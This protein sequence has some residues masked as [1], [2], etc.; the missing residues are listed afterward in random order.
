M[1]LVDEAFAT[2]Y[3]LVDDTW[4]YPLRQGT[5]LRAE[6][7]G[8]AYASPADLPLV[9]EAGTKAAATTALHRRRIAL[10]DKQAEAVM[11]A[12]APFLARVDVKRLA[13]LL[14]ILANFTRADRAA[15]MVSAITNYIHGLSG[16][17]TDWDDANSAAFE[18][19]VTRGWAEAQISPE[20]GPADPA[21]LRK[22]EQDAAGIAL[23]LY[24]GGYEWTRQQVQR[25]GWDLSPQSLIDDNSDDQ[26]P[27]RDKL[28][29]A[30]GGIVT[31][32]SAVG[33]AAA[34]LMHQSWAQAF[35]A[36]VGAVAAS[37]GRDQVLIS[38]TTAEDERVCQTCDDNEAN[39]PYTQDNVP[40]MPAHVNCRC[41]LERY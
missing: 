7:A 18:A 36:G 40:D 22:A 17:P 29:E 16:G 1:T 23:G 15:Q 30:V 39:G 31:A 4:A 34:D 24:G 38:W 41:A 32:H 26:G 11:V 20:H 12:A 14:A 25:L 33:A 2:G 8:I 27:D 6:A 21:K 3:A 35:L 19:A 13:Y 9:V 5:A 28:A 37:T 10:Y